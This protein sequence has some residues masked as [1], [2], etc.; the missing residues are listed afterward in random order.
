MPVHKVEGGYK[1]GEHGHVYPTK[2]GA[3]RQAAAAHAHGYRG[4]AKE[5][6][7]EEKQQREIERLERERDKLNRD[8]KEYADLSAR[9]HDLHREME[10]ERNFKQDASEK[11]ISERIRR[12]YNRG[13]P[14]KQAEAIAYSELGEPGK[15]ASLEGTLDAVCRGVERLESRIDALSR[16]GR[17]DPTA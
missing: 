6:A 13:H 12:E 14:L 15:D 11:E 7:H 1:W 16:P 8:S 17:D 2:E 4:D 9:I 5:D 10:K 3:E